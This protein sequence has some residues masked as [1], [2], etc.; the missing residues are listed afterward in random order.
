MERGGAENSIESTGEW[1]SQKIRDH[2][3]CA[4]AKI[5]LQTGP[6]MFDHIARQI[7]ADRTSTRQVLEQKPHQLAGT[8]SGIEYA[9]VPA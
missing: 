8:A 9:F 7:H 3:Q 2:K 4:L 6:R 1:Q 5:R